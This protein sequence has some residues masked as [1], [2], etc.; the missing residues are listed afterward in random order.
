MPPVRALSQLDRSGLDRTGAAVLLNSIER[1]AN[2]L[3]QHLSTFKW[4]LDSI[5]ARKVW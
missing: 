1:I 5:A 3:D 4:F 2:L